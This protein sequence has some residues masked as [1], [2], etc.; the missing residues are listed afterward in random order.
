LPAALVW[1]VYLVLVDY[2]LLL[3]LGWNVAVL[4]LT[5]GFRQFSHYFTDI[6]DALERD[7]EFT[8]R[9]LLTEWRH[10][11]VSELPRTELLRHVIEHSLLAAHRHVFGV[12]FLVCGDVSHRLRPCRGGSVPNRRV[13]QSLLGLSQ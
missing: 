13:R 11:D 10:L 9:N 4:Y 6:R 3:G 2:S 8:A 7:D 12:F 1:A 5:L